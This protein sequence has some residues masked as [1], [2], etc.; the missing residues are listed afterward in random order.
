MGQSFSSQIGSNGLSSKV[1]R[2]NERSQ[3]GTLEDLGGRDLVQ[4]FMSLDNSAKLEISYSV[5]NFKAE[6][7]AAL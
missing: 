3:Q 6:A 2:T 4:N 1:H 7:N 5:E